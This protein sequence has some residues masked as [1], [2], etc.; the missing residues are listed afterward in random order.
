VTPDKATL[1]IGDSTLFV[2][3]GGVPPYNLYVTSGG[4]VDPTTVLTAGSPFTF[5]AEGSGTSTIIIVDAATALKTVA[6][7]VK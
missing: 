7:T 4:S 1:S 3:T 6:V 2:L 5:T